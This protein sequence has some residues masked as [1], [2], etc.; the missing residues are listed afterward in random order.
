[1]SAVELAVTTNGGDPIDTETPVITIEGTAPVEVFSIGVVIDG[2]T[3]NAFTASFSNQSLLGWS[4]TMMLT[5]GRH[6]IDF[7]A[8]DAHQNILGT[9][10]TA[11]TVGAPTER[12]IRGDVDLTGAVSVTDAINTLLHLFAGRE[13]RCRDAADSNDDGDVD[14]TDAAFILGYLF[15]AGAPPASP[16][17]AAGTDGTA[18]ALGCAE[19]LAG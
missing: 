17:P 18:D 8:F 15:E 19:G 12:F 9:A 1:M 13:I 6:A 16:F 5:T 10:A 7:V 14:L 11:V 4:A 2:D 3:E